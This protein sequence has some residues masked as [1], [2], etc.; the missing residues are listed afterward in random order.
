MLRLLISATGRMEMSSNK[1]IK[2]RKSR[3][4]RLTSGASLGHIIH[5]AH[6]R[7]PCRSVESAVGDVNMDFREEVK[8]GCIDDYQFKMP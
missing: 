8:I 7:H 2:T 3:F 4:G 1:I 5:E 6:V